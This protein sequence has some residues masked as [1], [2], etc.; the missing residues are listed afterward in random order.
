M[1]RG[2]AW[3]ILLIVALALLGCGQQRTAAVK[4]DFG[5]SSIYT[6]A[7][8]TAAVEVI[9]EEFN[10]WD[11]C[12]LYRIS[13]SSDEACNASNIAWMNELGEAKAVGETFTQCIM[14]KSHFHSPQT[15]SGGWNPDEDYTDWQWW[16]AR[17]DKGQWQLLTW[18]Y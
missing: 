12:E 3:L 14:F 4:L 18:G 8:M 15:A 17:S 5:T 10:T 13:Y 1:K 16:L 6:T 7:D 11:G 2:S 9:L